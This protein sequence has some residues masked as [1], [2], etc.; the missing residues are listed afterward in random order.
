MSEEQILLLHEYRL[1]VKLLPAP[2]SGGTG[3]RIALVC[4]RCELDLNVWPAG[5]PLHVVLAAVKGHERSTHPLP[6]PSMVHGTR[7]SGE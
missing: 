5:V 2:D 4:Q 1:H 3:P 6:A 7:R